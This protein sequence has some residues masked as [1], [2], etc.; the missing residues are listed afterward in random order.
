MEMPPDR[1]DRLLM[2]AR[3]SREPARRALK[4]T[5]VERDLDEHAVRIAQ[6]SRTSSCRERPAQANSRCHDHHID[7][8]H[9]EKCPVLR[10]QWQDF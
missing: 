10:A 4:T 5:A 7:A 1:I 9:P 3:S 8:G 6:L 2:P